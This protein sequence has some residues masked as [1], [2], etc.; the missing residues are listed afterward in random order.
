MFIGGNRHSRPGAFLV[1][2]FLYIGYA[3]YCVQYNYT[4]AIVGFNKNTGKVI[5]AF[6]NQGGLEANDVPRGGVWMSGGGL[7]YDGKGCMYFSTGNGYASQLKLVGNSVLVC[8]P[9]TSLEEPAVN[10]KI[11]E[12]G[13]LT[14]VDFF[15]PMDKNDL[16]GLDK[17]LG[18]SL[19]LLLP[20]DVFSSPNH[21]RISVFSCDS[22]GNAL[23][24]K[25]ADTPD[26]NAYNIG[27]SHGTTTSFNG[28]AYTG[29]LWLTN[30]QGSSLRVY[31]PIPP[32]NGGPLK[33]LRNFTVTGVTNRNHEF[34]NLKRPFLPIKLSTV[35]S[36][37][38]IS[39]NNEQAGF[40]SISTVTLKAM[41][42]STAPRSTL[43]WNLGDTLL[44][45]TNISFSS[46]SR[47]GPWLQPNITSDGNNQV[48]D[49][50]FTQLPKT[51]QSTTY[52]AFSD[53]GT[54]TLDVLG[55][56]G[57]QPK[58][59]IA[60][61]TPDGS[62]WV[63]YSNPTP[64]IFVI[65]WMICHD[66]A[67]AGRPLSG[68]FSEEIKIESRCSSCTTMQAARSEAPIRSHGDRID[69]Y[70]GQE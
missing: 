27:P 21:R 59:I 15:M 64:F 7:V 3:S 37:V 45:L 47:N 18:T 53:G 35:S 20:S 17:D 23:F 12:D 1:G 38:T 65:A 9:P 36:D 24:T 40:S 33:L 49:F 42:H 58:A 52:T 57:T 30:V 28:Q 41:T 44:P 55:D 56:A 4:G 2:D 67:G 31:D 46:V 16:D 10:A 5:E 22:T 69:C 43:F 25:V 54:R 6:T 11:D 66:L 62:G 60:F 13:T 50:V 32:S 26:S 70:S 19:L 14:I 8:S 48:G 68:R 39:A 29:V 61:Q 63:P 51:M 34:C